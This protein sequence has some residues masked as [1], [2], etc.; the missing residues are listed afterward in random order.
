[1]CIWLPA[2]CLSRTSRQRCSLGR[3]S[4]EP[5]T[6]AHGRASAHTCIR[7]DWCGDECEVR[8][9]R[10]A[11]PLCCWRFTTSACREAIGSPRA[12]RS[13]LCLYTLCDC[14]CRNRESRLSVHERDI[15]SPY[16]DTAKSFR[17]LRFSSPR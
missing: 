4:P 7:V 12:S 5:C 17:D 14:T 9:A 11:A 6:G 13:C 1:L 16:F 8:Y 3:L 15:Q 2:I 10:Y